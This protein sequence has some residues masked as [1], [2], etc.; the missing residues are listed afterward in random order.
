MTA[1]ENTIS[2]KDGPM[3]L[4]LAM[5]AATAPVAGIVVIQHAG[6][7][8]EFVG[9]MA[10]R[11][12]AAGF[13]AAAPDL[14]HR[15]DADGD[16]R[17]RMGQL[18]DVEVIA[19]VAA[20]VDALTAHEGVDGQHLGIV[21]F[22]MGGRVTYMMAAAEARF[23]AAVAYYDGNPSPDDMTTLDAELTRHGKAHEFHAYAGAGHAFMDFTRVE[24]YRQAASA[25]SWNRTL[26]FLRQHLD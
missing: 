25:L 17:S 24:R 3:Q 16:K 21:G 15:L 4:H 2:T 18:R 26:A 19:D 7:V 12:A 20:T 10:D 5:P 6:G 13:A 1:V 8:D 14:Y 22:C 11:L 9:T 23:R